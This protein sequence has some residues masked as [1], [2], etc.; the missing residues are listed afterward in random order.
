MNALRSYAPAIGSIAAWAWTIVAGGGGLLL[1]VERGPW[2]LTNGWFA[3]CSGIAACPATAWLV[4][5]SLGVRPAGWI[6]FAAAALF[7]VAGHAAR[8]IR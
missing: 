3:L 2:P 4:E 1:L 5:R 7:F 6:R 8:A